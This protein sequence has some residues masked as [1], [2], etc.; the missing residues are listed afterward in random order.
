L[1]QAALWFLN[2][3]HIPITRQ[4]HR[5]NRPVSGLPVIHHKYLFHSPLHIPMPTQTN[6]IPTT[7]IAM[8]I[9]LASVLSRPT[10]APW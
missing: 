10:P 9:I 2:R 5:L 1:G 4:A 8:S 3:N 7:H 6:A